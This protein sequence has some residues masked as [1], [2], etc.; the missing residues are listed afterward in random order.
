MIREANSKDAKAIALIYNYYI[1]NTTISFEEKPVNENIVIQRINSN[2]KNKWWI[3]QSADELLGYAYSTIWKPRSA[4]RYTVE[5]SIYLK[6][7]N[8]RNGIGTA[9]YIKLLE[10]LKKEG[11][12]RVLAGISLPNDSS[13]LFHENFGFK[14]VG[15][16]EAVG[17]KFKKWI[18]I[19]YWEL[20]I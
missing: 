5:S 10:S 14:K 2:E 6:P 15:Q 8:F 12:R 1:S 4:Y 9:L 3:Y 11:F 18:D 7:N 20:K 13:V 19:G 17:Y 16:L